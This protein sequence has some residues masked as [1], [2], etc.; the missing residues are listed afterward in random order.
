MKAFISK[1]MSFEEEYSICE[2]LSL[3]QATI[4]NLNYLPLAP[5][6][7]TGYRVAFYQNAKDLYLNLPIDHP[8][9]QQSYA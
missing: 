2:I 6:V 8:L 3:L 7:T 9:Q 4:L 5:P 1:G